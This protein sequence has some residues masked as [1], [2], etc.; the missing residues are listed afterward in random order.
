MS[1]RSMYR[2][3]S[4]AS[5]V[6]LEA[7][8]NFNEWCT[9]G[10]TLQEGYAAKSLKVS[11]KHGNSFM[12]L[13]SKLT[14][15]ELYDLALS[16]MPEQL[17]SFYWFRLMESRKTTVV[18]DKIYALVGIFGVDF[19]IAYG[20]GERSKG[21]MYEEIAKQKGDLT[22]IAGINSKGYNRKFPYM[23][24]GRQ[25]VTI[26]CFG[27]NVNAVRIGGEHDENE[28]YRKHMDEFSKNISEE[29]TS[30]DDKYYWIP[31]NNLCVWTKHNRIIRACFYEHGDV[32]KLAPKE[33]INRVNMHY[34]TDLT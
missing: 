21:R 9:R 19:Q 4:N 1:I 3:Y 26:T 15:D 13:V 28:K 22:W 16:K 20:E 14:D 6:Y 29:S 32:M 30:W 23:T 24:K 2:W 8:T 12:E 18:E 11:P 17:N 7:F 5:F 33:M 31:E 34:G 25:D 27:I 10:W